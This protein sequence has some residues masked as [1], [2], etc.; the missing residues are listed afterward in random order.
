M[1]KNGSG[2][3]IGPRQSFL[4]PGDVFERASCQTVARRAIDVF[5]Q[6]D[7]FVSNPALQR[8]AGFLKFDP[9]T[10]ARVIQGT[11]AGGFHMSQLMAQ[12]MVERGSRG[13]IIFISSGHAHMPYVGSVAYNAG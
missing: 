11:L 6:V 9:D 12:H 7:I 4:I 2:L 5:G 10:F 8:R 1:I 13:K 3:K